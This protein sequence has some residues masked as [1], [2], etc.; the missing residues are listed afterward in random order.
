[1]SSLL[2]EHH[3]G[4]AKLTDTYGG[5]IFVC[6]AFCRLFFSENIAVEEQIRYLHEEV[7]NILPGELQRALTDVKWEHPPHRLALNFSQH[8]FGA[9]E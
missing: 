5:A 2:G 9:G 4:R 8:Q 3:R 7:N 6:V 1:M